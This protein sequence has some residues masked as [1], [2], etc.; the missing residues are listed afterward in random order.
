MLRSYSVLSA[1]V[2]VP[3]VWAACN[4]GG[5]VSMTVANKKKS[6]SSSPKHRISQ[7]LGGNDSLKTLHF[8]FSF[9]PARCAL[10]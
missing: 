5:S 8:H 2:P 1:G 9:Q 3:L 4:G 6:D 10:R 7:L